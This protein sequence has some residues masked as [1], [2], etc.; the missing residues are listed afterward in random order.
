MSKAE[1]SRLHPDW[2][3]LFYN[4]PRLGNGIF[5]HAK[6]RTALLEPWHC[7]W[8]AETDCVARLLFSSGKVLVT[9]SNG[10]VC[11]LSLY[12]GNQMIALDDG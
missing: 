8:E 12:E 10:Q 3:S 11:F 1:L 9:E 5:A 4:L 6:E 2:Y 7:H